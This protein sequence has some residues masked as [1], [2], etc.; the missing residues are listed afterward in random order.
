MGKIKKL[1]T[2][3][4]ISMMAF[5]VVGC[6]MIAK[7]PEAIAKTVLAKVG[8]KKIT[9]G[10]V[11]NELQADINSLK[12]QYGEDYQSKISDSLKEQLLSVKEQVLNQLVTEE[13]L[14]Q[15][16]NEL[17]LVP[18]QEELDQL[19]AER[20][21]ELKEYYGG[22]ESF[23]STLDYF[24]Y[25]DETFKTFMENQVICGLVQ[26]DAVKDVTVTDEEL[27]QYYDENI[28]KFT[29]GPSATADHLLFATE[30]DGKPTADDASLAQANEA[31]AKL[32]SG[33]VTFDQLFEQYKDNK[34][35]GV[36][37]I[38]EAL[39]TVEYEQQNF[40]PDFLA[41][42]KELSEGQISAPVKSSFGYHIIRATNV[43][44]E[45]VVQSFDDV[46]ESIRTTLLNEKKQEAYNTKLE[47]WKKELNVKTY[48]NKIS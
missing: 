32:D 15:K 27:Q 41:G 34:S 2:A 6:N 36:Y 14:I 38:A 29:T 24:G 31:K 43:Q 46:K 23:Q 25:T 4:M 42:L 35:N 12:E 48:E 37:P 16:A 3:A 39:G 8:D 20:T 26:E 9:L 13:V 1:V 47:E 22:E 18:A 5:S 28:D 21:E 10:D 19:V 11:D 7:T 44:K 30:V 17:N 45:A 33:E 40:D